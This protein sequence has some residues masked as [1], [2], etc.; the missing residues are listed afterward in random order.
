M[1]DTSINT[2]NISLLRA[3]TLVL[4]PGFIAV[5]FAVGVNMEQSL[6]VIFNSYQ[7][8]LAIEDGFWPRTMNILSVVPRVL[9]L[10]AVPGAVFASSRWIYRSVGMSAHRIDIVLWPVIFGTIAWGGV[11]RCPRAW[12]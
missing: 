1:T 12:T 7:R 9:L 10:A 5:L 11:Y 2:A 3:L 8:F 4:G 6:E